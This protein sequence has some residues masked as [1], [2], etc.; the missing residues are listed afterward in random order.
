MWGKSHLT[1]LFNISLI[2]LSKPA[3][4]DV[5]ISAFLTVSIIVWCAAGWAFTIGGV[6]VIVVIA[7]VICIYG[8][9]RCG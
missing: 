6:A 1:F 3:L 5:G 9:F 8:S 2:F 4:I 7:S